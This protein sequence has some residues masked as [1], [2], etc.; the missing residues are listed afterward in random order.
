MTALTQILDADLLARHVADRMVVAVRHP[1]EPLT[2]YN[3]TQRCQYEGAWDPVTRACRGLIVDAD[4]MVRARPFPKFHNLHEHAPDSAAGPIELV[5]PLRVFDKLDG[6]LGIAYRRPSDDRIAWATRGS[7]ISDQAK[8][9]TAWWERN[10]DD[11]RIADD[12][13]YLVEI[14]Y[15][16]NRIVVDYAGRHA[17][18]LLA[19]LDNVT[20]EHLAPR[21]PGDP[22]GWAHGQT[23][24]TFPAIDDMANLDRNARPSAEGYVVLSGDLKT[25]VKLKGDEY[26]RLHKLLTGVSNVTIWDLLRNGKP[27]DEL[28]DVVPDEFAA[29]VR[30][31]VAKLTAAHA[32][33]MAKAQAEHDRIDLTTPDRKTFAMEAVKSPNKAL[34]FALADGKDAAGMAWRQ[35]KPERT[36][37]YTTEEP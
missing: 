6:S 37:P 3:Y 1:D 28:L 30:S 16:D 15:P 14:I 21:F 32:A 25:R 22:I 8:W 24:E 2:L 31:T 18:V 33:L 36:L 35:V 17:L 23:V 34:L 13:T 5:P 12:A 20:G 9:A 29:W 19:I 11:G 26:M 10:G 7:F 4:G 27:I